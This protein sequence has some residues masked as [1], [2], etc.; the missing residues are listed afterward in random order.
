MEVECLLL[1]KI[2]ANWTILFKHEPLWNK[3][4]PW[5][6]DHTESS[7]KALFF[8]KLLRGKQFGKDSKVFFIVNYDLPKV[9]FFLAIVI[10]TS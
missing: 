10:G 2:G 5:G 7:S 4:F 8:W 3:V 9:F 6:V 1:L